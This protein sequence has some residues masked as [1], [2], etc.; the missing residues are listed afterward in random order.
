MG[1]GFSARRLLFL[2]PVHSEDRP[3]HLWPVESW[4]WQETRP[5]VYG[6][7]KVRGLPAHLRGYAHGRASLRREMAVWFWRKRGESILY[8]PNTYMTSPLLDLQEKDTDR[9]E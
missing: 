6:A 7:V 5:D 3:N 4:P 9:P 1:V 8:V 2:L